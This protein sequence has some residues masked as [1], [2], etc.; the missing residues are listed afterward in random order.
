VFELK[1]LN[2][3]LLRSQKTSVISI[4][5]QK[6]EWK[7]QFNYNHP[8]IVSFAKKMHKKYQDFELPMIF[9]FSSPF[10]KSAP[11]LGEAKLL[12]TNLTSILKIIDS[13]GSNCTSTDYEILGITLNMCLTLAQKRDL[14][15]VKANTDPETAKLFKSLK[16]ANNLMTEENQAFVDQAIKFREAQLRVGQISAPRQR[17]SN[18][19][20]QSSTTHSHNPGRG[21]F[22]GARGNF[23][24]RGQQ[25]HN[26]MQHYTT[27]PAQNTQ[28]AGQD[29]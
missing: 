8:G 14:A 27:T 9:D 5:K 11:E 4:S 12:W 23:R 17:Y 16:S 21:N 13:K 26:A 28:G 1:L 24:G 3:Q 6:E 18:Y 19:G 29:S 15:M 2:E 10:G 25:Y 20:E 22:R 7:G